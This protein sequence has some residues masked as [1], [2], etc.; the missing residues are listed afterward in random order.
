MREEG[1]IGPL[2]LYCAEALKHAQESD[3]FA[4]STSKMEGSWVLFPRP[5]QQLRPIPPAVGSC[6][7][8][9]ERLG[10][11]RDTSLI[12][13]W[14]SGAHTHAHAH[15]HPTSDRRRTERNLAEFF[16]P[17]VLASTYSSEAEKRREEKG[18]LRERGRTTF[19][20]CWAACSHASHHGSKARTHAST[21]S[22]RYST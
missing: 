16:P 17:P 11:R 5:S 20:P 15:A 12:S 4:S 21:G 7:L 13:S 9:A 10:C 19:T 2:F 8:F 1:R 22:R 18:G 6:L 3:T 14:R